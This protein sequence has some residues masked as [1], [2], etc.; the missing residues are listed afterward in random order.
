M[1]GPTWHECRLKH[2]TSVE[3]SSFFTISCFYPAFLVNIV[4]RSKLSSLIDKYF[5]IRPGLI[6]L[7]KKVSFSLFLQKVAI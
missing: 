6:D 2:S 1:I 5:D 3:M 7:R 4:S